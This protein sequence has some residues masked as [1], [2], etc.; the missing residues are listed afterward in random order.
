[1]PRRGD[2]MLGAGGRFLR[3]V[4][5]ADAL[6]AIIQH[7]THGDY[8]EAIEVAKDLRRQVQA[9]YHANPRSNPP[10]I[11]QGVIG[12]DVHDIRYQHQKDGKFYKHEFGGSVEV[13]AV[14]RNGWKELL[15]VHKN[16]LPLWD[17]F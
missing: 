12:K 9:G 2:V 3:P 15:L 4:S 16:H 10:F 7:I 11:I 14:V 6:T 17:E 5:E 8:R 1:M 13:L